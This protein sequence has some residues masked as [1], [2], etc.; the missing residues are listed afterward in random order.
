ML[1][2]VRYSIINSTNYYIGK[3]K[4]NVI[5]SIASFIQPFQIVF[6]SARYF[7]VWFWNSSCIDDNFVRKILNNLLLQL[8]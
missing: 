6:I 1:T 2:G 8:I 7:I 4:N 5:M 3:K